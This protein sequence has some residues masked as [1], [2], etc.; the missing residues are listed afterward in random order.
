[1]LGVTE[2]RAARAGSRLREND[3]A[4]RR[5]GNRMQPAH[6]RSGLVTSAWAAVVTGTIV[7]MLFAIVRAHGGLAAT[8]GT[9]PPRPTMLV[10]TPS[11]RPAR[12]SPSTPTSYGLVRRR[13]VGSPLGLPLL[14]LPGREPS[15]SGKSPSSPGPPPCRPSPRRPPRRSS[16]RPPRRPLPSRP[17][18]SMARSLLSARSMASMARSV[19]PCSSASIPSPRSPW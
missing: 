5:L 14:P 2:G 16:S 11:F 1:M 12:D 3:L 10:S 19:W 9:L 15:P 4:A 18:S 7:A 17:F 8:E 13:W 6:D